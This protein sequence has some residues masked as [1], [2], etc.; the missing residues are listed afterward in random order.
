M[1]RG[2]L[3]NAPDRPHEPDPDDTARHGASG[4]IH[5]INGPNLNRLGTR[6]PEVYG[7]TTLDDI[8]ADCAGLAEGYGLALTARQ[9]NV[10]GDL[11]T[12]VHQA[13]DER[14]LGVVINAGAYTHTSIALHDA[15]KLLSVPVVETHLSNTHA[16][17]DFRHHSAIAPAVTGVVMGFG[18]QSYRLA[19]RAICERITGRQPMR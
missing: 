9:S 16:R 1:R 4:A 14:A 10:E 18:A 5:L 11:V 8:V 3:L 19:V 7:R 2:G 15:L 13:V 6:E 12:F 17:E